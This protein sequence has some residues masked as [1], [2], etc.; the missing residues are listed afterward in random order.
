MPK[1]ELLKT[2][3]HAYFLNDGERKVVLDEAMCV[4]ILVDDARRLAE[5]LRD[6]LVGRCDSQGYTFLR[7]DMPL[8]WEEGFNVEG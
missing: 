2:I 8:P 7:S 1:S 6:M 3:R 5:R 4:L